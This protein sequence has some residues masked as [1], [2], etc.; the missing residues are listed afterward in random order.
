M[1]SDTPEN[2]YDKASRYAVNMDAPGF[3]SWVLGLAPELFAFRGWLNTRGIP[4]PGDTERAN[5]TVARLENVA[6]HGVPWVLAVEFQTEP[7]PDM[8]GRLLGY[9]SGLWL[10]LRPDEERGSR[11]HV[12]AAVV[13]LTG[14][15]SAGR[16]LRWPGTA[17]V[18]HLGVVERNLTSESAAALLVEVEGGTRSR[19]LLPWMALM[20][21]GDDPAFIDRWKLAGEVEPNARR[22]GE[23]EVLAKLFARKAGR[24]EIWDDKLRGWNV[25]VPEIVQEW[26]TVGETRGL[27]DMILILGTK[28]FG[29]APV[30]TEAA[31]HAIAD[32]PR[33]ERMGA[34]LLDAAGWPDLLTTM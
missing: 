33:L 27:C 12:G 11:F 9:L 16:E 3:L 21:G 5:D 29:P 19:C 34:R 1:E 4:F 26:I 13:N 6:E 24:K 30:G 10:A 22:R 32:R 25:E 20:A 7:D 2:Y 17:L 15:G 23:F 14:N 18:T 28:R 8:F 31:L